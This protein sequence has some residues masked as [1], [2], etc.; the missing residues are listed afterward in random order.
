MKNLYLVVTIIFVFI[1][2]G[3]FVLK[4][5]N[6]KDL[7]KVATSIYATY[8]LTT[9]IADGGDIE[10][11]NILPT[12]SSPHRFLPTAQDQLKLNSID[13]LFIIGQEFDDWAVDTAKSVNQNVKIVP[14]DQGIDLL[15]V[16]DEHTEEYEKNEE[17]EDDK[18]SH[19]EFDPHYWLSVENAKIIADTIKGE[20]IELDPKNQSRY[21]EN[22]NKLIES[23]NDLKTQSV[24]K[25]TQLNKKQI[26]TFHN[27][28]SY[29]AK[30]VDLEIVTTIEEFPG[31][32][33]SP[34]YIADVGQKIKEHNIKILFSEPQLSTEVVSALA[35]DY[36][37]Q[38]KTL[39]PI[40]SSDPKMSY[41]DVIRYNINI[42]SSSLSN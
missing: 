11:I 19:G 4:S 8:S 28:F 39:D 18:H 25:I 33:P 22:Y 24:N 13:K 34:A 20:L 1:V 16:E 36:G 14:L 10:V 2:S 17:H 32:T 12:G 29:F 6:R 40:E 30:E 26:I 9:Q 3:F 31:Q 35:K 5:Q 27:A 37:A 15:K 7:L 41:Q 23:L 42:I 38:V 21:L